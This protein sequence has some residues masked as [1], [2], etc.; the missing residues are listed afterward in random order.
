[1]TTDTMLTE[2]S[3]APLILKHRAVLQRLNTDN[4][5]LPKQP[6]E[7]GPIF[8]PVKVREP[9]SPFVQVYNDSIYGPASHFDSE[10]KTPEKPATF[11][12]PY[13]YPTLTS[14]E[15][16][17]LNA[18]WY[19]TRGL[20]HDEQMLRKLNRMLDLVK[21]SMGWEIGIIGLVDAT[22]YS[23]LVTDNISLAIVPRR[24]STCSHTINTESGTVF[25]VTDMTKDWRFEHSPPV[26]VGGLRSYAGTQ[27][28]LPIGMLSFHAYSCLT[29]LQVLV[30][31]SYWAVFA[32]L[33]QQFRDH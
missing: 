5:N 28:R 21:Q 4:D 18:V 3:V 2:D 26:E 22:V 32:L 19:Y 6:S 23:R 17:R 25:T 30:R 20:E 27:L 7:V 13:L 31:M 1:M 14:N 16:T 9:L 12:D 15:F 24:E 33:P 11:T 8:D 29:I 10:T